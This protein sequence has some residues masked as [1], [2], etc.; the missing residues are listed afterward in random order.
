MTPL[1][2]LQPPARAFRGPADAP[3]AERRHTP[4]AFRGSL[5]RRLPVSPLAAE[6]GPMLPPGGRSEAF[7]EDLLD[8][9]GAASGSGVAPGAAAGRRR[10]RWLGL[11]ALVL[12]LGVSLGWTGPMGG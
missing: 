9:L 2:R 10:L 3:G 4:G 7:A 11:P 6:P 1:P 5:E 12:S 8:D